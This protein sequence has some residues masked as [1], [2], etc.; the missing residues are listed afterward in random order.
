MWD[1]HS[2][3]PKPRVTRGF[4]YFPGW[5]PRWGEGRLEGTK[6]R[7]KLSR[8]SWMV[9]RPSRP[10]QRFS[11]GR[12][13]EL[14]SVE[15]HSQAETDGHPRAGWAGLAVLIEANRRSGMKV[16]SRP[17]RSRDTGAG[18]TLMG[19]ERVAEMG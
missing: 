7:H 11:Q 14:V 9:N 2:H 19:P 10:R 5:N 16:P 15:Q 18:I 3:T 13:G 12:E 6:A 1:L 4:T 8:E 17:C